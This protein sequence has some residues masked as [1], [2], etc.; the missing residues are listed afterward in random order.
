MEALG[1][2]T[3]TEGDYLYK[4]RNPDATDEDG[5]AD[6]ANIQEQLQ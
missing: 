2:A 3:K 4:V 6:I 1:C 5:V